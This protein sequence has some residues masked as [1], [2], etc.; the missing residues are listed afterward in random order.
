MDYNTGS[1]YN[2]DYNTITNYSGYPENVY[3]D[4]SNENEQKRGKYIMN[5]S[6]RIVSML[7]IKEK[8][9]QTAHTISVLVS[10]YPK[11][12]KILR[13]EY[14]NLTFS[15]KSLEKMKPYVT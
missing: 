12:L 5:G 1:W 13:R 2:C 3:G 15:E 9:L 11:I 6:Y 14:L 10:Q 7:Y 8:F 4:L